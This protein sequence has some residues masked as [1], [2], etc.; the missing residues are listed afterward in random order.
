MSVKHDF[1]KEPINRKLRKLGFSSLG[2][3]ELIAQMGVCVRDHDHFRSLMINVE[4]AKRT[5]AY[6][7]LR[8]HLRFTPKPL[9]VYLSEAAQQ[10]EAQKLPVWDEKNQTITDY[11]NYHG[12]GRPQIEVLAERAIKQNYLERKAKG[13]LIL[14]CTKCT[15]EMAYPGL[16]RIAAYAAAKHDGWAFEKA[17]EEE[18][19]SICP[20]CPSSTRLLHA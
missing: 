1:R 13:T 8:A 16:N 11:S 10:A 2:E 9:E 14:T 12:S 17:A 4:P 6:E 20:T 3:K 15:K 18:E 7:A 5:I 19:I